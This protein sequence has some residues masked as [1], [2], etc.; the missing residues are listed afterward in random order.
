ALDRIASLANR[1]GLPPLLAMLDGILVPAPFFGVGSSPDIENAAMMM[2]VVRVRGLGL[3]DRE[4]YLRDDARSVEL[5]R[6][7]VDH[8]GR[9][10]QMA[11]S[12]SDP[13]AAAET[14]MRVETALANAQL[15][16]VARRNPANVNHRMT[17]K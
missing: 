17:R 7:Y 4:F 11:G 13:A 15:D 1:D 5:R 9:M 10:L 6:Q 2:A 16:A 3:P 8:V 12:T 14:V